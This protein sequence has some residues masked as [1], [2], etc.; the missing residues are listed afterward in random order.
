MCFYGFL[1]DSDSIIM[2]EEQFPLYGTAGLLDAEYVDMKTGSIV[3]SSD[4][5][6][7]TLSDMMSNFSV[8][9]ASPYFSY[10]EEDYTFNIL[11]DSFGMYN[12]NFPDVNAQT[13]RLDTTV[14]VYYTG[15][16][17]AFSHQQS[18]DTMKQINLTWIDSSIDVGDYPNLDAVK[19]TYVAEIDGEAAADRGKVG[20]PFG[21]V[22]GLID[23]GAYVHGCKFLGY[24][25]DPTQP[26]YEDTAFTVHLQ[27]YQRLVSYLTYHDGS[28][29]FDVYAVDIG[30]MPELPEGYED[31]GEGLEFTGWIGTPGASAGNIGMAN[32]VTAVDYYSTDTEIQMYNNVGNNDFPVVFPRRRNTSIRT[33]DTTAPLYSVTGTY[34][35]CYDTYFSHLFPGRLNQ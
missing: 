32:D 21:S 19:A 23:Y 33:L 16:S 35:E 12:E 11:K 34:D 22:P 9:F 28:W 26:I 30:D 15:G 18:G 29:H 25:N 7:T 10:N 24:A 20:V 31:P 13:K 5:D 17:L 3:T 14:Y 8:Q 4:I 27:K 6:E 2:N 1:N